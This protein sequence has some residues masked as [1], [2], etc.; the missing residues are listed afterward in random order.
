[1]NR[2]NI[3]K[4]AQFYK[5]IQEEKIY[6]VYQPVVSLKNGE[7]IGYE[8]LTRISLE[9]TDI[10]TEEFFHIA[11]DE[12]CLWKV[13]EMCRFRSLKESKNKEQGKKLFLNV[14]PNVIKDPMFRKG[15]TR[16]YLKEFGLYPEDIVFEITERNSIDDQDTFQ[17]II[18]HYKAQNF[19]IA[20]DDFGNG[21]AGLNRICSLEPQYI[22]ID[23]EIVSGIQADSIKKSL[24]ES[25]VS[26]CKK[27]NIKLIA[28]GI[29][30]EEELYTLIG[31]GVDF[32]QGFYLKRPARNMEEIPQMLVRKII[33]EYEESVVFNPRRKIFGAVEEICNTGEVIQIGERAE[34]AYSHLCKYTNLTEMIVIDE[35]NEA[36]GI[37]TRADV[38][39][40]FGGM[41]GYGVSMKKNVEELMNTAPLIVDATDRIDEVSRKALMRAQ[42]H[43]YDAV[44]VTKMDKYYGVVS[45]KNLLEAAISIQV[46]RAVETNPLTGLPGNSLIDD[47]VKELIRAHQTFSVAYIDMDNFKAYN[48]AYGFSN[49]DKMIRMLAECMKRNCMGGEFLGHVGGDDFVIINT[50]GELVSTLGAIADD[51]AEHVQSLY[52]EEDYKRGYIVSKNRRGEIERFP[53]VTISI[54]VISVNGTDELDMDYFSK[55]IARAKKGSK[56]IVGNSYY[57][58]DGKGNVLC[59]ECA[60]A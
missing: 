31:M 24:V 15:I 36:K 56:Q 3:E 30:T 17:N 40:A 32:G 5:I 27:S 28:E 26:F 43:I 19:E 52:R 48:D 46:H 21:Y 4:I 55:L 14:D 50:R 39:Q 23:R 47:E 42:K 57:C 49:G 58:C 53:M 51:F 11:E 20:I 7:I 45:V 25:M 38:F 2:N 44:I 59:E 60:G 6:P 35:E 1:M 37:L 33:S 9:Q 34:K 12:G 22:K 8:A 16:A 29:E 13:E 10:E 54:G 18:Q 41:Y